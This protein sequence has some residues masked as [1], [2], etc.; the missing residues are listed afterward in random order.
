MDF[1]KAL[2]IL[3]GRMGDLAVVLGG[4]CT[5]EE[6]MSFMAW[7][8]SH[9]LKVGT[10]AKEG[11]STAGISD[12]VKA[13]RIDVRLELGKYPVLGVFINEALRKG[14][15]VTNDGPDLVIK[16]APGRPETVPTLIMHEGVNETGLLRLGIKGIPE[17]DSYLHVGNLKGKLP[18][19]T[20]VLG[21]GEEAD[22]MFPYALFAEKE[23]TVFNSAVMEL[24]FKRSRDTNARTFDMIMAL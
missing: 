14:A 19:F 2:S 23:G 6:A 24:R 21:Y 13:R 4:D 11:I 12:I 5:Q 8:R 22:L 18:G 10:T 9:D 1:E 3:R 17:A 20:I 15:V 7:A 16:E